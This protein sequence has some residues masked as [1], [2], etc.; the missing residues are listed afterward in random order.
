MPAASVNRAFLVTSPPAA[1]SA[2]KA[3]ELVR[4]ESTFS[5]PWPHPTWWDRL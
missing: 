3:V 5:G 2:A 1:F 4:I